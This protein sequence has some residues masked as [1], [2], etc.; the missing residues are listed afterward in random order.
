MSSGIELSRVTLSDEETV[1]YFA[2]L[3]DGGRWGQI[4]RSGLRTLQV[5]SEKERTGERDAEPETDLP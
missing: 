1:S 2:S 3:G 5:R 4:L